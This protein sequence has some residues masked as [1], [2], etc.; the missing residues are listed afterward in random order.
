MVYTCY[1]VK[2]LPATVLHACL[3]EI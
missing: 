2:R 3:C 1:S